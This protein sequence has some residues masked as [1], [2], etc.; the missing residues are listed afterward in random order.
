[1]GVQAQQQEVLRHQGALND[2]G[3][4]KCI[5]TG[6]HAAIDGQLLKDLGGNL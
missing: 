6:I 1:M 3:I 2:N 4:D 5:N